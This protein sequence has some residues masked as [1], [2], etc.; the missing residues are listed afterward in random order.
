[1]NSVTETWYDRWWAI[2]SLGLCILVCWKILQLGNL[3]LWEKW[4]YNAFWMFCVLKHCA[5]KHL[6]KG[7]L[8][9]MWHTWNFTVFRK[10]H[11]SAQLEWC[12]AE[13]PFQSC[14]TGWSGVYRKRI[15]FWIWKGHARR[16]STK[17]KMLKETTRKAS[18]VDG[19]WQR[20]AINY[21][22]PVTY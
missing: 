6:W 18:W 5:S 21:A 16:K 2:L 20:A 14:I 10:V 13:N 17:I 22:L 1:M 3:C 11:D 4:I 9:D 19:G 12:T 15:P 7:H 8:F